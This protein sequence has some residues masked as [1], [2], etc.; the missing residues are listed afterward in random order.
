MS[1]AG[2]TPP[3]RMT[4]GPGSRTI[5]R[6]VIPWS[7]PAGPEVG[8][9]LAD[10]RLVRRRAGQVLAP[11][12]RAEPDAHP[13]A[14]VGAALHQDLAGQPFAGVAARGDVSALGEVEEAM[15]PLLDH[16]ALQDLLGVHIDVVPAQ[17]RGV[18]GLALEEVA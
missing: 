14:G 10:G 8:H 13:H 3:P 15:A 6:A 4:K 16:A 1:T 11:R 9:E 12:I 2:R 17:D 5:R 18:V 7:A